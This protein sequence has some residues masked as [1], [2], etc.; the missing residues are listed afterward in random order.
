VG[1]KGRVTYAG[2]KVLRLSLTGDFAKIESSQRTQYEIHIPYIVALCFH[3]EKGP[4]LLAF[5]A[6]VCDTGGHNK[7]NDWNFTLGFQ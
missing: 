6:A 7:F 4:G 1:C 3:E 2:W 5:Q